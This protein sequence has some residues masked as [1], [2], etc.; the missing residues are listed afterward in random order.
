MQTVGEAVIF[1]SQAYL[2]TFIM[3][4]AMAGIIKVMNLII[5]RMNR[6]KAVRE[7]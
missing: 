6:K 3:A 7:N 1:A 5:Q 2:L 4:L